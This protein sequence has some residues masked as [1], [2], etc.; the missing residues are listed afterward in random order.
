MADSRHLLEI[1]GVRQVEDE[2]A[3]ER[4]RLELVPGE[5]AKDEVIRLQVDLERLMMVVPAAGMAAAAARG[6]GARPNADDQGSVRATAGSA[7]LAQVL[8]GASR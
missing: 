1:R 8:V 4:R 6:Q 2:L 7:A 5:A 3:I